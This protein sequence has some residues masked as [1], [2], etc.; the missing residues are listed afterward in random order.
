ME[1][2]RNLKLTPDPEPRIVPLSEIQDQP[3]REDRNF[4]ALVTSIM[5]LGMLQPPILKE[6]K[7]KTAKYEIIAGRRRLAAAYKL[8]IDTVICVVYPKNVDKAF[9]P[10]AAIAENRVRSS[11]IGSD[12]IALRLMVQQG[13]DDPELVSSMT[14]LPQS[15]TKELL[16]LL[17]LDKRILDGIIDGAIA[18]TT[19]KEVKKLRPKAMER[20]LAVFDETGKLTASDVRKV[21]EVQIDQ[22]AAQ[23]ILPTIPDIPEIT[24]EP[25][26]PYDEL[27]LF[28]ESVVDILEAGDDDAT[29]VTRLR[30]LVGLVEA[31]PTGTEA[32]GVSAQG[33]ADQADASGTPETIAQRA[34]RRKEP[35]ADSSTRPRVTG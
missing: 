33:P 2:A 1:T 26:I 16:S 14:G 3:V 15:E 7:S 5:E 35:R 4:D 24:D 17:D 10:T 23:V 21:R 12:I 19:A 34:R 13:Y 11:N 27:I 9:I 32:T 22:A 6:P 31:Q 30:S 28:K 25:F 8:G 18:P 29:K 20:A